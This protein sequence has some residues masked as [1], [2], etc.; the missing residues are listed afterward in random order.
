M[1]KIIVKV[2][3]KKQAEIV[4]NYFNEIGKN[5]VKDKFEDFFDTTEEFPIF[6]NNDREDNWEWSDE[7]YEDLKIISF[8]KFKKKYIK[9]LNHGDYI[10]AIFKPK[11][12]EILKSKYDKFINTKIQLGYGWMIEDG[13]YKGQTAFIP[14]TKGLHGWIPSEDLEEVRILSKEEIEDLLGDE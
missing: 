5:D 8:S 12:T 1:K 2:K 3:N 7:D 9:E 13:I 4:V 10:E 11:K 14:A 6:I